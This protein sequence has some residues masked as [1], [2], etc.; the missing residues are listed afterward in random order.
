MLYTTSTFIY[1]IPLLIG[2]YYLSHLPRSLRLVVLAV[3]IDGLVNSYGFLLYVSQEKNTSVLLNFYIVPHLLLWSLPPIVSIKSKSYKNGIVGLTLMSCALVIFYT[4]G[5][6]TELELNGKALAI[7]GAHLIF[8]HLIYIYYISVESKLLSFRY[9]PL[10][11]IACAILL[12]QTFNTV[13]FAQMNHLDA[14]SLTFLWKFKHVTYIILHLV[15]A[16]VIYWY[17]RLRA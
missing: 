12:Y 4:V 8:L 7:V 16:I 11:S 3:L 17:G 5:F 15:I 2:L 1:F 10:F 6:H 13:I 9:H 14:M